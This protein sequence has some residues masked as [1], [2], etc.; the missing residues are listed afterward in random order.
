MYGAESG[1]AEDG[2]VLDVDGQADLP[3][4]LQPEKIDNNMT[5]IE[6]GHYQDSQG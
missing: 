1:L 6:V 4:V 5:K 3:Q 2:V